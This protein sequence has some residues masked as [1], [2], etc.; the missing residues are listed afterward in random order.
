MN[1]DTEISTIFSK[2]FLDTDFSK[3]ESLS[4]IIKAIELAFKIDYEGTKP[5][6]A[7]KILTQFFNAY[8]Q[9][10]SITPF[11]FSQFLENA[12]LSKKIKKQFLI[13]VL[14]DLY[15]GEIYLSSLRLQNDV[16]NFEF[17]M[18]RILA[19]QMNPKDV[20]K[21][22][23]TFSIEKKIKLL[24]FAFVDLREGS[25]VI[26]YALERLSEFKMLIK[27]LRS[28]YFDI[29]EFSRLVTQNT[30]DFSDVSNIISQLEKHAQ[31]QTQTFRCLFEE[32]VILVEDYPI[33]IFH[34]LEKLEHQLEVNQITRD[35]QEEAYKMSQELKNK[36]ASFHTHAY[37]HED[38]IA[39]AQN[40]G[41]EGH[42]PFLAN[43]EGICEEKTLVEKLQIVNEIFK[44]PTNLMSI[45]QKNIIAMI[46]FVISVVEHLEALKDFPQQY[47]I[48]LN[49][50]IFAMPT[51]GR[52]LS[53]QSSLP[54]LLR[55]LQNTQSI[56]ESC[57]SKHVSI[58]QYPVFVFDQSEES[59]FK[60]NQSYIK[61]LNRNFRSSII[62]ISRDDALQIAR[63]IGIELLLDTVGDETFG[64]GGA[65]NCL[66][67][68]AP[69][70][71][72][73]FEKGM[74]LAEMLQ[75]EQ[76]D[77]NALFEKSVLEEPVKAIF[78][79]DDD[80]EIS[81]ANILSDALLMQRKQRAHFTSYTIGRNTKFGNQYIDLK[82]FFTNPEHNFLSTKWMPYPIGAGMSELVTPFYFCLNLPFAGE[83]GHFNRKGNYNALLL[84]SYHLAGTRYPSHEI[85]TRFFVGFEKCLGGHIAKT[86]NLH[87]S[88]TI[89]DPV[90]RDEA[91]ALPW[92]DE[93]TS[94]SLT[95]LR[96]IF[97]YVADEETKREMQ[98][99]FWSNVD[100]YLLSQEGCGLCMK[101]VRELITCDIG[102]VV[103]MYVP[104]ACFDKDEKQALKKI[105]E[106]Y[107]FY[108]KDS[109][110]FVEYLKKVTDKMIS[111]A[112]SF[113]YPPKTWYEVF[114]KQ[115]IDVVTILEDSR[116]DM[117]SQYEMKFMD[118]P[119][120]QGLYLIFNSV[121]AAHFNEIVGEL[122]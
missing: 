122:V 43:R 41:L 120:V 71:K 116:R 37:A 110:F 65:R 52:N 32:L 48:G 5:E 111:V 91:C 44:S 13:T 57:N 81:G 79:V 1:R 82:R 22:L 119:L 45:D 38:Y 9:T 24:C 7:V 114:L 80:V 76:E 3:S 94:V 46:S 36:L 73:T 77:L 70:L 30:V 75:M 61:K 62:L 2:L 10:F 108:Q 105:K 60:K 40:F 59:V 19:E 99:R 84:P 83:E 72:A 95:S 102:D 23:N 115:H 118:R 66:F 93:A 74:T 34:A 104:E 47:G 51:K 27:Y 103:S 39:F 20:G 113:G 21:L 33:R 97:A 8:C 35:S 112:K 53:I 90:N 92:N 11:D 121:G 29:Q 54:S 106:I 89:L 64:Y 17:V 25:H 15:F 87:I 98:M 78:M 67:L 28:H 117:E 101:E 42:I 16:L 100:Y 4:Q 88:Y 26:I 58:Y 86:M 56:A 68:L 31:D 109:E 50:L 107:K 6:R 12:H 55:G 96:D 18:L 63:K 49:K 69:L 14:Y 85:P